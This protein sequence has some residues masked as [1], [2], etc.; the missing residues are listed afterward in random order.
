[1]GGCRCHDGGLFVKTWVVCRSSNCM[2]ESESKINGEWHS[3]ALVHSIIS[4]WVITIMPCY[5]YHA[6]YDLQGGCSSAHG[7]LTIF[8]LCRVAVRTNVLID[9]PLALPPSNCQDHPAVGESDQN[10]VALINA[11]KKN[12]CNSIDMK[13][14]RTGELVVIV[15]PASN[16]SRE[17]A[18][19][20]LAQSFQSIHEFC[21]TCHISQHISG[22]QQVILSALFT[23]LIRSKYHR[24]HFSSLGSMADFDVKWSPSGNSKMSH[25]RRLRFWYNYADQI[26]VAIVAFLLAG[27][28]EWSNGQMLCLVVT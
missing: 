20:L 6:L 28:S 25:D 9:I 13:K 3:I 21:G 16:A 5:P 8:F 7:M 18:H 14:L 22:I 27:P 17:A 12:K 19:K 11:C 24:K 4:T 1:M 15:T 2:Y 10:A 26:L 23:A